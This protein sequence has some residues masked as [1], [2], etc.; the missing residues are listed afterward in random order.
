MTAS[1]SSTNPNNPPINAI[2]GSLATRW[3][4]GTGQ[5]PGQFFEIDFGGY[6]QLSQITLNSITGNQASVDGGGAYL[7]GSTPSAFSSN[8]IRSNQAGDQANTPGEQSRQ[9]QSA[10]RH[11]DGAIDTTLRAVRP[12]MITSGLGVVD[13]FA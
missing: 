12:R 7:L 11:A 13:T 3:S 5:G 8:L 10:G 4:T 6:V 1:S 2:D 9:A